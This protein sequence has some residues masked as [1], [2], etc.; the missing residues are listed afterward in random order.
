MKHNLIVHYV[1]KR[2]VS[3]EELAKYFDSALPYCTCSSCYAHTETQKQRNWAVDTHH[4]N[5]ISRATEYC[6]ARRAIVHYGLSTIVKTSEFYRNPQNIKHVR[7]LIEEI[8]WTK[9]I[10]ES[11]QNGYSTLWW[12]ILLITKRD[13]NVVV[14]EDNGMTCLEMALRWFPHDGIYLIKTLVK[15]KYI[16]MEHRDKK[17]NTALYYAMVRGDLSIFRLICSLYTKDSIA[18][19]MTT[20]G[21]SCTTPYWTE[22]RSVLNIRNSVKKIAE[23]MCDVLQ[24][25]QE[26]P[27]TAFVIKQC[28]ERTSFKEH[29]LIHLPILIYAGLLESY[30]SGFFSLRKQKSVFLKAQFFKDTTRFMNILTKI[31]MDVR[32]RIYCL[33]GGSH[34]G[35]WYIREDQM[36]IALYFTLK[37]ANANDE[38]KKK[39]EL[40]EEERKKYFS[41]SCH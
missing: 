28:L 40:L 17:G 37:R 32:Q 36:I 12:L 21:M 7:Q 18:W 26:M 13:I 23:T 24:R 2:V 20:Y 4:M 3:D 11:F 5:N 30:L 10:K 19:D 39:K 41:S 14:D 38:N 8:G 1:P 31:P 9:L 16:N 6:L 22:I 34:T 25:Q 35:M 15:H 27:Q 29:P 33:L